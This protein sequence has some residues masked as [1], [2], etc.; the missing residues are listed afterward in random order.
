MESLVAWDLF[1]GFCVS[2]YAVYIEYQAESKENYEAMCDISEQVS[3][4]KV[5]SS[6]YS[7]IWSA[8][9][10]ITKDSALDKSNAFY[11]L[12][13]YILVGIIFWKLRHYELGQLMLLTLSTAAMV[14]CAFLSYILADV[15]HT[16][17]L[18]CHATYLVNFILFA[19]FSYMYFRWKPVLGSKKKLHLK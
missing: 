8:L 12:F 7:N 4:T 2:A 6:E 17:C 14:L 1:A 13:F 3:C 10:F 18:V 16:I 11:G 15:L 9:G 19:C 5:L